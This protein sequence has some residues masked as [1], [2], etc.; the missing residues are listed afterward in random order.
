MLVK[1][2][3]RKDSDGVTRIKGRSRHA[4]KLPYDTRHPIFLPEAHDVTRLVMRD[5]HEGLGHGSSVELCLTDLCFR[6]WIVKGR[7]II[8]II[9]LIFHT[10]F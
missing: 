8:I 5:V 1:L 2:N 7:I 4:V 10:I 9:F 6:Y 3:P